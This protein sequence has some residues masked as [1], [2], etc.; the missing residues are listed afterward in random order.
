MLKDAHSINSVAGVQCSCILIIAFR[1]HFTIHGRIPTSRQDALIVQL[2]H[3][4][5]ASITDRPRYGGIRGRIHIRVPRDGIGKEQ[6][7][8]AI[9]WNYSGVVALVTGASVGH[10]GAEYAFCIAKTIAER[11]IRLRAGVL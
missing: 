2:A 7:P 11:V 8:T 3:I 10:D 4:I 1:V 5:V 9:A 6:D